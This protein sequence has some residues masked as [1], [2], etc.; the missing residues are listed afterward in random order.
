MGGLTADE[1]FFTVNTSDHSTTETHYFLADEEKI[2]L[3]LFQKRNEKIEYDIDSWQNYLYIHTNQGAP[4]YKICRC[5]HE[6]IE[7]WEDFIPAKKEVVIGGF[8]FLDDW[9]IRSEMSDALP[10]LFVRNLKSNKEEEL[11]FSDEKVWSP[12]VSE[13]QKET[14]TDNVYISYSS[15]KTNSRALELVF[16]DE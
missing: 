15:P 10:R 11:K 3:K 1:K 8:D 13:I 14:D 2:N 12:S 9:I 16:G 7:N 5:K 4:D 6:N